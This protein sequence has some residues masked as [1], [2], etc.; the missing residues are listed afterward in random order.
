MNKRIPI[1]TPRM[2][3][4][5]MRHKVACKNCPSEHFA[6][7][8]ECLDMMQLSHAERVKTAFPC[9]WNGKRYCKGYCD[10]MGISDADLR[11]AQQ[12]KGEKT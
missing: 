7:D 5:P 12:S 2:E 1:P 8:P 4:E 11:A 10:R 3:A 9:A 6:P